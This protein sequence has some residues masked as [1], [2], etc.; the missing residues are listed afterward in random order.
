MA[1]MEAPPYLA[2]KE[3]TVT[4]LMPSQLTGARASVPVNLLLI[5]DDPAYRGY[6]KEYLE[7]AGYQVDCACNGLD[8]LNRF[9]A[10]EPRLAIL[11]LD[12]PIMSGF[13]L[14]KLI[15]TRLHPSR[16]QVPLIVVTGYDFEEV[17]DV[18]IESRPE[19]FLRKP[20]EPEQLVGKVAFL[21][22][23]SETGGKES[24]DAPISEGTVP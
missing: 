8:G 11:D 10:R 2:V 13:R 15:R 14:L 24:D 17:A 19:A 5:E 18:V 6:L 1:L 16:R 22:E 3:L 9:E 20:F 12:M 7:L 23:M 21:L 4:S